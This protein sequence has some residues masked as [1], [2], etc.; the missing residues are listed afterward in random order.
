MH[1][2]HFNVVI[3]KH[4]IHITYQYG[5]PMNV[6]FLSLV[7]EFLAETPKSAEIETHNHN[8]L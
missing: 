3:M 2:L 7:P 6:K 4:S 5:V 8:N 1:Y